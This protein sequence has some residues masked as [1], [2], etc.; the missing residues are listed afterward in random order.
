MQSYFGYLRQIIVISVDSVLASVCLTSTRACDSG[1]S[2]DVVRAHWLFV[3]TV[4]FETINVGIT[5]YL[6]V[7]R[8]WP[9][10]ASSSARVADRRCTIS[11]SY[12][13]RTERARNER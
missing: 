6:D 5:S 3:D 9:G 1:F 10:N 11:N 8:S 4:D 2:V 13:L 12:G 7:R